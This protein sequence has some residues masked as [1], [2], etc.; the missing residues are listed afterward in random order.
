V[1]PGL[2]LWAFL[3]CAEAFRNV[4]ASPP[5]T[6]PADLARG[7]RAIVE[8]TA[9]RR[10]QAVHQRIEALIVLLE[11]AG[12]TCTHWTEEQCAERIGGD[13]GYLGQL[14]LNRTGWDF[15]TWRRAPGMREAMGKVLLTDE[16]IDQLAWHQ[17]GYRYPNQFSR[18]FRA[19]F[20]VGPRELRALVHGQV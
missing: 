1:T 4:M 2:G 17:L 10:A 6:S 14:L 7:I 15:R 11:T 9:M 5:A 16:R 12:T 8:R 13:A 18:E 20:G 19:F 3:T